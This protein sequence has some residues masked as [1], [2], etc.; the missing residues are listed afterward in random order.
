MVQ[1]YNGID[2]SKRLN[3]SN[4]EREKAYEF[5]KLI[6]ED[7][8]NGE[9]N[10]SKII[11]KHPLYKT[12]WNIHTKGGNREIVEKYLYYHILSSD[13]H[14]YR[15]IES[16]LISETLLSQLDDEHPFFTY[17]KLISYLGEEFAIS[18]DLLIEMDSYFS[19]SNVD[20]IYKEKYYSAIS[21]NRT[22]ESHLIKMNFLQLEY[23][24]LDLNPKIISAGLFQFQS[25]E[26][27]KVFDIYSSPQKE[28]ILKNLNL[29]LPNDELKNIIERRI[30]GKEKNSFELR[31]HS[32]FFNRLFKGEELAFRLKTNFK[33]K[34]YLKEI[35]TI[36]LGVGGNIYQKGFRGSRDIIKEIQNEELDFLKIGLFYLLE[37]CEPRYIRIILENYILVNDYR[38]IEFLKRYIVL[39]G[40]LSLALRHS[41]YALLEKFIQT[42]GEDFRLI[43]DSYID[44]VGLHS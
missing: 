29:E 7:L 10:Q 2:L 34:H 39:D 17:N 5:I 23:L 4:K 11:T 16:L 8:K 24:L 41:E 35:I 28:M 22:I 43:I 12:G 36:L 31:R 15:F 38:G 25:E 1:F 9:L 20:N 44:E 37:G 30:I 27:W 13:Y 6:Y 3:I 14:G 32:I 33:S 42:I 40:I 21:S 19:S 26:S 18:K